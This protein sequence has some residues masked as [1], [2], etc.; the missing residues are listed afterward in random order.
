MPSNRCREQ[1]LS[2]E[3]RDFIITDYR[4]NDQ[5]SYPE[6]ASCIKDMG[7][8]YRGIYV[9]Q[10][11]TGEITIEKYGYNAIPNCYTLLNLQPLNAAGILTVQNFPTLNLDGEGVMIGFI[12]TGIDYKNSIFLDEFGNTRISG[13]WDQTIQSGTLPSGIFYGS[14]YSKE[15]IDEA[16]KSEDPLQI[17]PTIDENGHGT[18]IA[19]VA[20][21]RE[22]RGEQ[23]IGVAPKASIGVVKLKPAKRYLRNFFAIPEDAVCFQE[24]DIMMGLKYL[25]DL[26]ISEGKLLVFCVALG[27]N[28]GGHNGTTMLSRILNSYADILNRCVVIGGGNEANKRHH[29]FGKFQRRAEGQGVELRVVEG[30]SAFVAEVWTSLPNIVSAYIESP[31]GERSPLISLRQGS[32]YVLNFSFDGTIVE[33][34]DRILFENSDAQVLFFRFTG[35]ASGIWKIVVEPIFISQGEFHIWL[36]IQE[37]LETD[38]FFLESNPDTTITE[39]G[40]TM[41]AITVSYYNSQENS[42]DINSGRGYTRD[43]LIKP[44][45]AVPGVDITGV[46]ADNRFVSRNGS[47]AATAFASG[48]CALVMQWLSNLPQVNGVTS[49]QVKNIIVIGTNQR[50]N[51]EYPNREWGYGTMDLFQS[52]NRLREI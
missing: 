7:L 12:D 34:E 42:I 30:T 18:F 49:S 45:F 9:D 11:Y 4:A 35:V 16:I 41:N 31:S 46:T 40:S 20:C 51:V 14:E 22:N 47:S 2:E 15:Q 17:V 33:I 19:S 38:V 32:R 48:A 25:H 21:G 8:G 28:F 10:D 13:I 23:F 39:P 50:N 52:L 5:F 1:I 29:Y 37:F 24:N 6:D 3:Y 44:D 27:T 43:G 36:P 26:A